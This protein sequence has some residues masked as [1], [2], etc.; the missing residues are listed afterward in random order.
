MSTS[1]LLVITI[2]FVSLVFAL[3]GLAIGRRRIK[4][5]PKPSVSSP[6]RHGAEGRLDSHS[7]DEAP[8]V[9]FPLERYLNLLPLVESVDEISVLE[10][11]AFSSLTKSFLLTLEPLK[12]ARLLDE[13]KRLA[14]GDEAWAAWKA[15]EEEREKAEEL[16]REAARAQKEAKKKLAEEER[17]LVADE[18]ERKAK[19]ALELLKDKQVRLRY[20]TDMK[21]SRGPWQ[22]KKS[23]SWGRTRCGQQFSLVENRYDYGDVVEGLPPCKACEK[24]KETAKKH[25][26]AES[27]MRG[28]RASE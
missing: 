9:F 4:I 19:E 27:L 6:P 24:A 12:L 1:I 5:S 25:A 21:L 18:R 2:C 20:G 3:A 23:R 7:P 22:V 14:M 17:R 11:S 8:E 16:E 28:K 10:R 26:E 13:E 15:Q